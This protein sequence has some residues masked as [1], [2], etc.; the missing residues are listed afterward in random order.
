MRR[1]VI[2]ADGTWNRPDEDDHGV[3]APTNVVKMAR[4]IAPVAE[5]GVSQVTYYHEGVGTG[6]DVDKVLGGVFGD[7]L[8]RNVFD[9]YRFLVDN[10][11]P[12]DELFF[13][14]FSRGAYTV[15]S[16]AGLIRNSGLLKVDYAGMCR[17]AFSLYRDRDPGKHPNSDSALTFRTHYGYEPR[18]KCIGVWDT[19][20]ALGI[21][22]GLFKM[23]TQRRYA[24]HDVTL[25]SR[26]ENAFHALAI[27]ERRKPFAPTLWEQPAGDLDKN[28][29]E[30]AWFAGVHSNV[31]GGYADSRL[32]DITFRWMVERVK[33]RTNLRF[34]DGYIA[35]ATR[36][37]PTGVLY[38][39]MSPFYKTIG[40]IE[41]QI[42]EAAQRNAARGVYTWEYVHESARNRRTSTVVTDAYAPKNLETY[43]ERAAPEPRV[44]AMLLDTWRT[45]IRQLPTS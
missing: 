7:G 38:D 25:S 16:L 35:S 29:L 14:G 42:D 28:W 9:C 4:A 45:T 11:V 44:A 13:F 15:R 37:E 27:D 31:G 8:D 39:S 30:Q 18:I 17:E 33:A 19:V 22:V 2:C 21:P 26:I 23:L 34:N 41:R 1:L 24:F 36:P 5:R 10:Y 12:G 3:E 43:L 6:D 32:S 40:E 20:G